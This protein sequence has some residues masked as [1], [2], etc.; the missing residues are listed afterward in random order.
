M[1]WVCPLVRS[2]T[3]TPVLLGLD[4]LILSGE[5]AY[6]NYRWFCLCKHVCKINY[7]PANVGGSLLKVV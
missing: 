2:L 6:G 1:H 7:L 5:K 4:R 3:S